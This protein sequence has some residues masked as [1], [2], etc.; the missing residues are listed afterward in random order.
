MAAKHANDRFHSGIEECA[1]DLSKGLVFTSKKRRYEMNL[2]G[3]AIIW[4]YN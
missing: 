3:T 4:I 1:N 2:R